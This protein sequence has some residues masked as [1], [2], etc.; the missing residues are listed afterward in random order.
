MS[1]T[2]APPSPP[3]S[4]SSPWR[5][6]L[7]ALFASQPEPISIGAAYQYFVAHC[8]LK[9]PN[10]QRYVTFDGLH[11]YFSSDPLSV[12]VS[13]RVR[14][15]STEAGIR[16]GSVAINFTGTAHTH[17]LEEVDALVCDA[18]DFARYCER[19]MGSWRWVR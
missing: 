19:S 7:R 9:Y 3:R 12:E 13:V 17:Q 18:L 5:Q 2:A 16:T 4:P 6:I 11:V 15:S 14:I 8:A 1:V 10:A